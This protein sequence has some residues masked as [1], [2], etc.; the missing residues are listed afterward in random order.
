V[1]AAEYQEKTSGIGFLPWSGWRGCYAMF[2]V[3]LLSFG[4][5]RAHDYCF[6]YIQAMLFIVMIRYLH[7][8]MI[9][10]HPGFGFPTPEKPW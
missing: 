5:V 2:H 3:K 8:W 7:V 9:R 10:Y 6:G 1:L 4:H